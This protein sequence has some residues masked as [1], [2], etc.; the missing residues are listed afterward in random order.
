M[1]PTHQR[2]MTT[3]GMLSLLLVAVAVGFTAFKIV[4][5]YVENRFIASSLSSLGEA[6]DDLENMRSSE[7]RSRLAKFYNINN[8]ESKGRNNI[9]IDKQ[10]S[11]VLITV[12]YEE[13]I[14]FIHNIDLVFTF[15]NQLDSSA[16]DK[17]CDPVE[18]INP[19]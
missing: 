19:E 2:G 5:V 14:D 17:C 11:R 16:P 10:A 13:R 9:D 7:I 15:V 6:V 4:P 18:E 3:L 8:V 12:A 1:T